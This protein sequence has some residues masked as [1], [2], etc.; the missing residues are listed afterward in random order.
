MLVVDSND[1]ERMGE[2][3]DELYRFIHEDEL[4]DS[5][6]LVVAN[7]Q[8]LAG[9]KSAVAIGE[10]LELHKIRQNCRT[11]EFHIIRLI[12]TLN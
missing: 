3:K 8:D 6:L 9:A 1:V 5:V 12:Y 11:F 10:L 2:V 4:R 7:K